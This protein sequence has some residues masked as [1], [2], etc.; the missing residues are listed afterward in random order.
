MFTK[1]L[2]NVALCAS[3]GA[4]AAFSATAADFKAVEVSA[5]KQQAAS[6]S[7]PLYQSETLNFAAEGQTTASDEYWFTVSGAE[8]NKG[9]L[10]NT[11]QPGAL[12]RISRNEATSSP[13]KT[14]S[15]MLNGQDSVNAVEQVFSEKDLEAVGIFNNSAA[16][17]VNASVAAGDLTLRYADKLA[18]DELYTVNVKEK[19]SDKKL[20]LNTAK[21]SYLSAEKLSFA[22]AIET[23]D[24]ALALNSAKGII[25]SPSGKV[26]NVDVNIGANGEAT[27]NRADINKIEA[28]VNGL[29]E[30]RI[31]ATA[32]DNGLT[33]RRTGKVAFGLA[34][35]TASI[36]DVV[37]T[38]AKG[39]P[40]A[41]VNVDVQQA[42]R[43]EVRAVL[44]GTDTNGNLKPV[45]ETH[46]ANWLKPGAQ[47][48]SVPFDRAILAKS[49][50]KAPFAV[51]HVQLRDQGN[52]S[53]LDKVVEAVS[54]K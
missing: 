27:V 15:I 3:L 7:F 4:A 29:Y 24:S 32:S 47:S 21:L 48:I 37:A 41:T 11:T 23:G 1:K 12:V 49:G 43:Y 22:A 36:A 51:Q 44:L 31:D 30:L 14:D 17:R 34:K 16:L 54:V 50:L 45:M 6:F 42:G 53:S 18:A 20:M 19:N 39:A 38:S 8:L 13:L 46:A 35:A 40:K 28:P 26:Y 33:V 9:V 10:L 5:S 25:V 52:M 2:L